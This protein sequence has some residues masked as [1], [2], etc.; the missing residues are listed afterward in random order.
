METMI[1]TCYNKIRATGTAKD[2]PK[3][4]MQKYLVPDAYGKRMFIQCLF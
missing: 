1:D 4:L 2:P 3:P